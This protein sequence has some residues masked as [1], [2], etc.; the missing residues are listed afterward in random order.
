MT[1]SEIAHERGTAKGENW[2]VVESVGEEEEEKG[3]GGL[4]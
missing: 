1:P 2:E 3:K 4:V